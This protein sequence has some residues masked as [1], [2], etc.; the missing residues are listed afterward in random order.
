LILRRIFMLNDA[1][2]LEVTTELTELSVLELLTEGCSHL[3]KLNLSLS[4]AT[5]FYRTGDETKGRE[6]FLELIK[7]MEWFV[8]IV[9]ALRLKKID[10]AETVCA[11]RTL[12]E[13]VD[14]LNGILREIL[15]A[16]EQGDW[17]LLTDLLEYELVPQLELWLEIFSLLRRGNSDNLGEGLRP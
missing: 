6:F 7:G 14:V 2:Q 4:Q 9:S 8:K 12:V 1:C 13:S 16:Q 17:I 15:V 10:F 3:G 11:G 5:G